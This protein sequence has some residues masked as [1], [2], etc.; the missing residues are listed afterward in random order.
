MTDVWDG[1]P[2]WATIVADWEQALARFGGAEHAT[3]RSVDVVASSSTALA[4]MLDRPGAWLRREDV[5]RVETITSGQL[6]QMLAETAGPG[7]AADELAFHLARIGGQ[8]ELFAAL[9]IRATALGYPQSNADPLHAIGELAAARLE[10]DGIALNRQGQRPRLVLHGGLPLA[11][12]HYARTM[13]ALGREHA[14]MLRALQPVRFRPFVDRDGSRR[15]A[16]I[17]EMRGGLPEDLGN[18]AQGVLDTFADPVGATGDAIRALSIH[19]GTVQEADRVVQRAVRDAITDAVFEGASLIEQALKEPP[20]D[21]WMADDP[22]FSVTLVAIR[23]DGYLVSLVDEESLTE[24]RRR[25]EETVVV[26]LDGRIQ[27]ENRARLRAF[28]Q[29][30]RDRIGESWAKTRI[31]Q[32][33]LSV[34]ADALRITP[35]THRLLAQVGI[36][37]DDDLD[38]ERGARGAEDARALSF[39]AIGRLGVAVH[40]WRVHAARVVLPCPVNGGLVF[41]DD[42]HVATVTLPRPVSEDA[43]EQDLA[44]V[45]P[46]P[47]LRGLEGVFVDH[48]ARNDRGWSVLYL[49]SQTRPLGRGEAR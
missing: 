48:V 11:R 28:L 2:D 10:V 27:T 24:E 39:Q 19:S 30:A 3:V 21:T 23:D 43:V 8:R 20:D 9:M 41:R 16:S 44:E 26:T 42:G 34:P 29:E 45:V 47:A 15:P 31:A 37:A 5:E 46:T 14:A 6:H 17:E 22:P 7:P 33:G 35:L 49:R 25:T 36:D 13:T 40:G 18:I 4:G 38:F 32:P 1:V 12:P